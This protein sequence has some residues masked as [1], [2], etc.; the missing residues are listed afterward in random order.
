MMTTPKPTIQ[1]TQK[2][3]LRSGCTTAALTDDSTL[4]HS[5]DQ[6]DNFWALLIPKLSLPPALH[7]KPCERY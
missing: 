6:K 5:E 3:I 1:T 4:D 2:S 7:S